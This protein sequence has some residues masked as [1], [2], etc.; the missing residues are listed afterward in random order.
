MLRTEQ[1]LQD[2]S[3]IF[4]LLLKILHWHI[5]NHFYLVITSS[6]DTLPLFIFISYGQRAHS[7]CTW[8]ASWTYTAIHIL[9]LSDSSLMAR[10]SW[11]NSKLL[12]SVSSLYKVLV[13]RNI[14]GLDTFHQF[15][16]TFFSMKAPKCLPFCSHINEK[17]WHFR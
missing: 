4:G 3:F 17:K 16:A 8:S 5:A 6:L 7:L 11:M 13:S 15:Y 2:Y 1:K 12:L 10:C 9:D 14:F